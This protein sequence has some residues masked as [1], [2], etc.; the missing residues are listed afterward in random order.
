MYVILKLAPVEGSVELS[1]DAPQRLS[2]N[3]QYK[4]SLHCIE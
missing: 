3:K 2:S 1:K 4:N